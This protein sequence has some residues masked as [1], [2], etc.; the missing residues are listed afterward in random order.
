MINI[1]NQEIVSTSLNTMFDEHEEQDELLGIIDK[2]NVA[3]SEQ[4]SHKIIGI[5]IGL[6]IVL[7]IALCTY[8]SLYDLN[9]KV[10]YITAQNEALINKVNDLQDRLD[11]PFELNIP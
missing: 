9:N 8:I 7:I 6:C 2:L 11:K 3:I 10:S 5:I 4:R 1:A